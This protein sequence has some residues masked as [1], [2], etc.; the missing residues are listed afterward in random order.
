M[1]DTTYL[2]GWIL[3]NAQIDLPTI[4]C[5]TMIRTHESAHSTG[6]LSYPTIITQLLKEVN[7]PFKVV[8]QGRKAS[9]AVGH[10][11]LRKIGLIEKDTSLIVGPFRAHKP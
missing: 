4:L 1:D 9:K 5:H 11:T 6:S 10:D 3:D 2:I 7:V 8:P